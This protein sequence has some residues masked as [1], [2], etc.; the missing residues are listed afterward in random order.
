MTRAKRG[1]NNTACTAASL[2]LI[3]AGKG[4]EEESGTSTASRE[5]PLKARGLSERN[6]A[7][8]GTCRQS[9][10]GMGYRAI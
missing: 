7:M 6:W 9:H 1:N 3:I 10:W 4:R 2:L 8:W 5:T